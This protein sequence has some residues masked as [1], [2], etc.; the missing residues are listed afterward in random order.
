MV[1]IYKFQGTFMYDFIGGFHGDASKFKVILEMLNYQKEGGIYQHPKRKLFLLGDVIDSGTQLAEVLSIIM[2]MIMKGSAKI[3]MGDSE[4]NFLS[5][6]TP[7]PDFSGEYLKPRPQDH[8][9]LCLEVS[10][11]LSGSEI[12]KLINFIWNTPLWHKEDLFQAIHACWDIESIA[13][14]EKMTFNGKMIAELLYYANQEG[15]RLY[16][17]ME[18]IL[19]GF[20]RETETSLLKPTF[21]GHLRGME[22]EGNLFAYRF[23]GEGQISSEKVIWI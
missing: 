18:K 19:K 7:H 8:K 1:V 6:L 23:D 5:C 17:S 15:G 21:L 2:P 14:L 11:Q 22:Y 13:I 20:S 10:N 16:Q 9:D 12:D 3:I 4:F